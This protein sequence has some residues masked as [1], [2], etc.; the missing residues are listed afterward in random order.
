M[1]GQKPRRW[2]VS[3]VSRMDRKDIALVTLNELPSGAANRAHGATTHCA[4]IAVK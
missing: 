4:D 1:D 3:P 2:P